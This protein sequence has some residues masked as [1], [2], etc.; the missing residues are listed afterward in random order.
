M[1]TQW[2]DYQISWIVN[3]PDYQ[4]YL[5]TDEENREF[6]EEFY[7]WFLNTYDRLPEPIMRADAMRPF[8]LYH[9]GGIYAD[10]DYECYQCFDGI[11]EYHNRLNNKV[12]LARQNGW[13]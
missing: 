13:G 7:P 4:Y 6:L 11:L 5:W 12:L 8:Y 1:P 3:N 2:K 9:F 10:L